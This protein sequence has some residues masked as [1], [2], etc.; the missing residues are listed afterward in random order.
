MTTAKAFGARN[1]KLSF[2]MIE[3]LVPY[4]D[5][6]ANIYK[7]PVTVHDIW[8]GVGLSEDEFK[9]INPIV[10]KIFIYSEYIKP[11]KQSRYI[12]TRDRFGFMSLLK[13][14]LIVLTTL[15]CLTIVIITCL[16][17]N[18][19]LPQRNNTLI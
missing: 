5:E 13:R 19:E 7:S 4:Y 15:F 16:T 9:K 1:Y 14:V 18:R 2:S 3:A 17:R 10:F 12:E 6:H 11:L 8:D